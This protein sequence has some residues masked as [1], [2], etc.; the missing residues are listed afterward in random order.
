[1]GCWKVD[2][3]DCKYV[4][5]QLKAT[6]TREGLLENIDLRG[7]K[8]LVTGSCGTV[9]DQLIREILNTPY[10]PVRL[11]GID[12]NETAIFMQRQKYRD[13]KG[14]EF[15]VGDVR[16]RNFLV[17]RL[18][19]IDMLFHTAALKHVGLGEDSPDQ[20]VL[21]NIEG[22]Q[23]IIFSSKLNKLKRVIFTSSDKAVNPTNV[24]GA[25]KLM[26]ERLFSA[27]DNDQRPDRT[28]FASVRFGNVLTSNGSVLPIFLSQLRNGSPL[29]ITDTRMSRFI[30]SPQ[31]AVRLLLKA[32]YLARGGEVFVMKMPAVRILDLAEA[33]IQHHSS[34]NE[35]TLESPGTVVTG[36]N[37]GEKLYE[38]LLS[39]EETS[40]ALV[41][42]DFYVV[43]NIFK[44]YQQSRRDKYDQQQKDLL[45]DK[46]FIASNNAP[47]LTKKQ[48]ID[49]LVTN[50]LLDYMR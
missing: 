33:L 45:D 49:Y 41:L 43:P 2:A 31:Q 32:S 37:P 48:I 4:I 6:R 23:N 11:V 22:V 3:R 44:E 9:G 14:V 25:T 10:R 27:A 26:G 24:M 46:S 38:E 19:D 39:D 1:M 18:R 29:S 5:S 13:Y 35:N 15:Y 7:V 50:E 28:I 20:V 17:D 34:L 8:I 36:C 12:V 30:M 42:D 47:C 40:R 21:T 16:D